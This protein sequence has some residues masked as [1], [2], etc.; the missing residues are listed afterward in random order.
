MLKI[1]IC[2]DCN[3]FMNIL[4]KNI[5]IW[6]AERGINAA[7]R[8]FDN[9]TSLL[10]CIRDNG[11]FDLVFMDVE[12][13]KMNGL[14]TAARIRENDF[15]TAI[16]F[17]SQYE[18]YYKEAYEVHPFHFLDKPVAQARL[19]EVMDSYMKMKKRDRE[20]FTFN[21]NKA[22]HTVYLSDV[23]YFS[24]ERRHINVICSDEIHAFYGK[25]NDVEDYVA[26]KKC[27]FIRIHQSFLVNLRHVKE[28]HYASLV[29]SN[30][31][32]LQISKENR[33]K[34]RD[35]HMLMMEQ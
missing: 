26:S 10:Y 27:K 6:A 22:Q 4:E 7:V 2:D 24:S 30:G 12:M 29:M 18:N 11:M 23:L 9:G 3:S 5:L 1:A 8:K 21:V 25:L 34:L 20:T 13:K 16:I 33:R 32:E 35:I 15:I 31:D 14:E 17:I 28:Y 19:N